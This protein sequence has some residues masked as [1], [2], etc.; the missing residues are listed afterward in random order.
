LLMANICF[1]LSIECYIVS[2]SSPPQSRISFQLSTN[3]R[4]MNPNM[5]SY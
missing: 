2:S 4:G 3:C 5:F 1:T